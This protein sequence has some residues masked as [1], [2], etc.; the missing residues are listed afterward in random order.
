VWE[1]QK[2]ALG[3]VVDLEDIKAEEGE[4]AVVSTCY[5]VTIFAF[6]SPTAFI[7]IFPPSVLLFCWRPLDGYIC[8]K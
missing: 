7:F 2:G 1:P 4:L 5:F 6:G 3:I 8:F